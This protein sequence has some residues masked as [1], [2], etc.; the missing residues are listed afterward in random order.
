MWS[1]ISINFGTISFMEFVNRF[2]LKI[3]MDNTT[4]S[5]RGTIEKPQPLVL[6]LSIWFKPIQTAQIIKTILKFRVTDVR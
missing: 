2:V 6:K 4:V 3:V 1:T 5:F